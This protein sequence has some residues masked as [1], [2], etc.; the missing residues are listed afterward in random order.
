MIAT[1]WSGDHPPAGDGNPE[2]TVVVLLGLVGAAYLLAHFVVD[3]LQKRLLFVSG[4][5][6]ILLGVG[7]GY[8]AVFK[9]LTPLAPILALSAGWV[10]IVLGM[11]LD[12]RRMLSVRDQALRVATFEGLGSGVLVAVLAHEFLV[13]GGVPGADP[14]QYWLAAGVMG[15]AGAAGSSTAIDLVAERYDLQ[16]SLVDRLRRAAGFGDLMSI[17]TFGVLFCIFHET[18]TGNTATSASLWI[19]VTVLLGLALGGLFSVFLGGHEDNHSRFL[20]LV[21]IITFSSGAAFFLDLS[22]L[23]VNMI[24]AF[25]VTN[26][27]QDGSGVRETL[28]STRRPMSLVLLVFAGA[29]WEAPWHDT[30]T[31]DAMF[32]P[33][34]ITIA[35]MALR[36]GGKLLGCWVG[37]VG[38]ELRPD[39]ARGLLAQGDEAIAMALSLKLVYDGPAID[40]AYTAILG[41][42][43]AHELLAPRVLKGLLIDAG[44]IRRERGATPPPVAVAEVL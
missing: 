36:M 8:L 38:T 14:E 18:G 13:R 30:W 41:S 11:E 25:V 23:T 39:L 7:L 37:S 5:E 12:V 4:F 10:G 35:Y 21:G 19:L 1:A 2:Q 20:A 34:A 6:Y 42:V 40:V 32:A 44:V 22:L 17:G 16:H 43:I 27:L 28:A 29:L 31:F 15:C 9:D 24:L 26:S 3:W 33:I